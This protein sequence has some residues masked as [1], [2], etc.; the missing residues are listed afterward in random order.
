MVRF[1]S[2]TSDNFDHF[3]RNCLKN[4]EYLVFFIYEKV[5]IDFYI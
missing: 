3:C 2:I 1:F 4:I 5:L